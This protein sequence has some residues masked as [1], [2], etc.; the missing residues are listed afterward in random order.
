[1]AGDFHIPGSVEDHTGQHPEQ[2]RIVEVV[3][4]GGRM[5]SVLKVPSNPNQS[6]ILWF[7]EN[8]VKNQRDLPVKTS[9]C[10]TA[11]MHLDERNCLH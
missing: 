10:H 3:S 8:R 6:V 7:Y 2:L 4:A 9:F 11:K 1:M 5:R